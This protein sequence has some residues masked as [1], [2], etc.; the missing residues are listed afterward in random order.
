MVLL[1]ITFLMIFLNEKK[2]K[3]NVPLPSRKDDKSEYFQ[4]TFFINML[5]V[6]ICLG[7]FFG[8]SHIARASM[9][10][11]SPLLLLVPKIPTVT[12]IKSEQQI[13][14]VALCIFFVGY[15]SYSI[16]FAN[17]LDILPY[18]FFWE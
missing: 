9:Y 7:I 11:F 1:V 10:L 17:S 6:S 3:K 4:I 18:R 2:H 14:K 15:F 16:F 12:R 5:I 13:I 8:T